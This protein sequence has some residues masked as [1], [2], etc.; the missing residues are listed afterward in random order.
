MKVAI[1]QLSD[2]HLKKGN[3]P[4]LAKFPAIRGVIEAHSADLDACILVFS[5]DIAF[6]GK[7]A[8]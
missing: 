1:L 2:I 8:E 4:I 6:S 7:Q 3:N 5:G